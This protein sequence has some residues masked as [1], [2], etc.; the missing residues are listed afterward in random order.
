MITD[1]TNDDKFRGPVIDGLLVSFEEY[2]ADSA[3][4]DNQ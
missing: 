3:E 4:V 2:D 1:T